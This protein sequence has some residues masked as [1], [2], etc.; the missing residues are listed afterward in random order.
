MGCLSLFP[1]DAPSL[2]STLQTPCLSSGLHTSSLYLGLKRCLFF[3]NTNLGCSAAMTESSE[4][5]TK[6]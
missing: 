3:M 1:G 4:E 6:V 2:H 5:A